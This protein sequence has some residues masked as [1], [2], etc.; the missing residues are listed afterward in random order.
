MAIL[1]EHGIEQEPYV[2]EQW[3][4]ELPS[5]HE[6]HVTADDERERRDLRQSH[7][8][9]SI[10]PPGCVDIDDALSVRMLPGGRTEFG[11]HIADVSAFVKP[12]SRL[13]LEARRRST[14]VY[15]VDRRINMLP[16]VLS[17]NLCSLHAGVD[18]LAVSVLW[19][20]KTVS[21][22]ALNC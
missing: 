4:D 22:C 13:D 1:N 6:W 8:I 15:L 2:A 14:T 12:D 18:R 21:F 19:Y 10:D 17:E 16:E 11:V 5:A 3:K 9:C 7:V 20:S